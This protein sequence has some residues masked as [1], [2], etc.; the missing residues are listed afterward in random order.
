M[1]KV[2]HTG[3]LHLGMTYRARNYPDG[4]RQA[5]VEARFR[6]LERLMELANEEGCELVVIAGDLFHSTSVGKD[7]VLKAAKALKRFAGACVAVLPGNHDYHSE[8]SPLW[9]VFR[10]NVPEQVVVLTDEEPYPL[11]GYGLDAVLYPAPCDRKHSGENK[12]G[13]IRRLETKP[14]ATWHLGAAHGTVRGI[15]PDVDG[16]YF[17]M[18]REE[19]LGLGLHHWF[20]GHTHVRYPDA[21]ATQNCGLAYC[22]TAEPDG[23]DCNHEGYAWITAFTEGLIESRSV[24]TGAFRFA[25]LKIAI[26]ELADISRAL[27]SIGGGNSLVK[28]V[29]TGVLP[30][31]QYRE[32]VAFMQ[33]LRDK[34]CYLE[35]DDAA[36]TAEVTSQAIAE[37]FAAGSFP[38]LL[39]SALAEQGE[40]DALHL[41]YHLVKKVKR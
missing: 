21:D 31:E 12:L 15:S 28:L 24:R 40:H 37:E 34:L 23:F 8:M 3:D 13:W 19:L 14:E 36:L 22:G 35:W 10:E 11:A 38:Q 20:L 2:L 1:L 41:A 16:R 25:D 7:A 29:M 39:L 27:D 33:Q 4:L 32:R 17:P 9:T 26:R 30:Q 5:L 18:E 6:T